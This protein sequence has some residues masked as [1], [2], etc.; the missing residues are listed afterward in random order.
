MV[1]APRSSDVG[2]WAEE[3]DWEESEDSDDA[4]EVDA[5]DVLLSSGGW[6]RNT[7]DRSAAIV[8]GV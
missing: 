6:M 2:Q 1:P 8:Q 7:T 4:E 3:V 5:D